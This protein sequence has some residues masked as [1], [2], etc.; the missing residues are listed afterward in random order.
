M[1]ARWQNESLNMALKIRRVVI[2]EGAR[3]C[4]KTTLVKQWMSTNATYR[5]L[6]DANILSVARSDPMGF[7]SH[8]QRLMIIDEIQK[9]PELLSAIK[10]KVDE[11]T[12]P[13]QYLLTGSANIQSLPGV[14]ES[15]AGRVRKVR[16]RPLTVGE[17]LNHTPLFLEKAFNGMFVDR[18]AENLRGEIVD[19]AFQG[20]FPEALNATHSKFWHKDYIAAL[21]ERDLKDIAN[22]RRKDAMRALL[23]VLAAW[24]GKFMDMSAITAGLSIQRHTAESYLN[25]LEA[26]HLIE[27]VHAWTKTDYEKAA[28]KDKLFMTDTGMMTALLKWKKANVLL[29]GDQVGKLIETFVFTQLIAE[30][31]TFGERY[32]LYHYRDRDQR[33]IDFI[34]ERD[35]GAMLGIEVKAGS[36][37]SRSDAKHLA[38]F[39][40][41]I[42]K[43]RPFIG[44]VLNTNP[45]TFSLGEG[46]F[47]A[48]IS[49]LF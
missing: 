11:D 4:G 49:A 8:D 16:L 38:W 37:T 6:D 44:V 9:A 1:Y 20:G 19:M 34:V 24:S 46:L 30:V 41:N 23:E 2:L 43:G 14:N 13:G 21:L 22:I 36:N 15:L 47:S 12:R 42:A 29:N 33:E 32:Q 48:P 31:E 5:T 26:L 39:K 35:D 45:M 25:A 17:T 7:V 18:S 10:K 28:K 3:Q 40:N 27:R